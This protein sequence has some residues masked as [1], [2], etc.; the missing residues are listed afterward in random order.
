MPSWRSFT[1][2]EFLGAW[3][4][5]GKDGK[6]R[7]FVLEIAAVKG[8]L[9]KSEF[10]PKGDR[11]PCLYFKGARKG[12][13]LNATNAKTISSIAGS[14]DVN[15]WTGIKVALYATMVKSKGGGMVE[16]IRIRPMKATAAPE[17]IADVP[18]DEEMRARQ[19]EGAREPGDDNE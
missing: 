6:P 16:G 9:I 3:D 19:N 2:R 4:L 14:E 8:G 18:V 10:A 5:V 15:K 12:M 7:D 17:E 11:R 13:I 1:D